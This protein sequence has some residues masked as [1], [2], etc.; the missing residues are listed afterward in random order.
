[1]AYSNQTQNIPPLFKS[2]MENDEQRR[3]TKS[4][5]V[6]SFADAK[7]LIV[8]HKDF[9]RAAEKATAGTKDKGAQLS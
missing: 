3:L 2:I 7:R 8:E 1:M 9:M 6:V 4:S 5:P